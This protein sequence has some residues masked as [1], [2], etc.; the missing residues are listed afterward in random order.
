MPSRSLTMFSRHLN[1]EHPVYNDLDRLLYFVESESRPGNSRERGSIVQ[2]T[3]TSKVEEC[4][5][6]NL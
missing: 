4:Y 2:T 5:R 3:S 6:I 1:L